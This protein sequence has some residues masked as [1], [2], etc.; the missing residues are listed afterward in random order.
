MRLSPTTKSAKRTLPRSPRKASLR[1]RLT[2]I[3]GLVAIALAV[4]TGCTTAPKAPPVPERE[5]PPSG[6]PPLDLGQIQ[7]QLKM[8]RN[9][10]ELGFEEKSFNPCEHGVSAPPSC[11][12][13]RF[14]V[15][16]FQ[17]QCRDSVGTAATL[18]SYEAKAI[19]TSD[20]RWRIG[21]DVEGSVVSD[22]EGYAQIR[23]IMN[24]SAKRMKLRLAHS[25]K[26][27]SLSAKEITKIVV[28]G[29]WCSR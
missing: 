9:I 16:N 12:T 18:E 8:D 10:R 27:L 11:P 4:T 14:V 20:L 29:D 7:R 2:W 15:I 22:Y 19:E 26:W 23:A 24:S 21:N 5:A 17:I 25:G 13:Q 1:F 3:V 28:P 6:P